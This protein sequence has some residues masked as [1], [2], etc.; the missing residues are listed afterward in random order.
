MKKIT[1]SD[2]PESALSAET[3]TVLRRFMGGEN[4]T[5]ARITFVAGSV[6]PVHAHVNEQF[7]VVLEGTLRFVGADGST[8]DVH[9]GEVMHLPP[10]VPHGA[11]ALTDA[12]VLD[13]FAPIRVDWGTPPTV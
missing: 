4:L 11:T 13:V 10:H 2:L 6:L 8:T 3:G 9:A 5:L 1:L 12:T 7:T